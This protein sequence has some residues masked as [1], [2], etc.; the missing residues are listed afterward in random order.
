[1]SLQAEALLALQDDQA[2]HAD[3]EALSGIGPR[4][5]FKDGSVA[6]SLQGLSSSG[7]ILIGQLSRQQGAEISQGHA[8]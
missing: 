7:G 8:D 1:M 3:H 2:S 5:Q 6:T 4:P